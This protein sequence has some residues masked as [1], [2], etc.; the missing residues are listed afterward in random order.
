[1]E[2]STRTK[3]T[4]SAT[5]GFSEAFPIG[6]AAELRLQEK[7]GWQGIQ[8]V[9]NPC[10][11]LAGLRLWD[12]AEIYSGIKHEV[13]DDLKAGTTGNVFIEHRAIIHSRADFL[14]YEV[15]EPYR[16][17]KCPLAAVISLLIANQR[18]IKKGWRPPYRQVHGGD[19]L[20]YLG[21]LVPLKEY[22]KMCQPI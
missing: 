3:T 20:K 18:A 7:L 5:R 4:K 21:T 2:S 8:S 22:S 11:T 6:R 1:M 12:V 9:L 16:F 14:D 19:D 17:L 10:R 13:K 15:I